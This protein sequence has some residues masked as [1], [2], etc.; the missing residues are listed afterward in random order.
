MSAAHIYALIE[1]VILDLHNIPSFK[2]YKRNL[3]KNMKKKK[4]EKR[5]KEIRTSISHPLKIDWLI[6]KYKFVSKLPFTGSKKDKLR[7]VKKRNNFD[8]NTTL[9]IDF[10]LGMTICPGKTQP[11]GFLWQRDMN[12][13]L[14]LLKKQNVDIIV[15]LLSKKN[16]IRLKVESLF[17]EIKKRGMESLWYEM[18]DS[19]IPN[20]VELWKKYSAYIGDK[21]TNENKRVVVHCMGG[22]CRTGAF[23]LSV[24]KYLKL[25]N[26]DTVGQGVLWIGKSR[27]SAGGSASQIE[28]VQSLQ[29]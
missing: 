14:N 22:L 3:Q 18:E 7:L 12:I 21:L 19:T 23:V 25:I 6:P 4:K 16:I 8:S 27:K 15:T 2:S 1:D 10:K 20:D 13:D 26:D 29:F 5:Y 17:D 28:F 9:S 24:L 11:K